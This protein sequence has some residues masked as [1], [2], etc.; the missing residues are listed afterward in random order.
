MAPIRRSATSPRASRPLVSVIINTLNRRESLARTLR[1]LEQQTHSG[2]EVVVVDGPSTDGTSEMLHADFRDRIRMM[3]C[4]KAHLGL[5]RNLG[6]AAA[7][8]EIVVFTDDDTVPPPGWLDVLV[9]AFQDPDV[10]AVG[11]P[12]FDEPLDRVLWK[13]CT[14][15][16]LG[17]PDTDSTLR[18]SDTLVPGADPFA[19][20]AG[21]NMGFRRAALAAVGGFHLL[22]G[23]SYDDVEVCRRLVDS[24][25][26][27][28]YEPDALLRHARAPSADRDGRH[29]PRDGYPVIHDRAVFALSC[30]SAHPTARIIDALTAFTEEWIA[31]AHHRLA[32]GDFTVAARDRFVERARAGL[33]DGIVDGQLPPLQFTVPD[34]PVSAFK[35]FR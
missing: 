22:L 31:S 23:S 11:G 2:F 34:A 12:V 8:G 21:C 5:S 27:I 18:P 25:G 16:R 17:E 26:H 20:L 30:P 13:R 19:Y 4:D 15:T 35:P 6:V 28:A 3:D 24:G 10:A 33:A 9:D 14:C 7:A 32:V 29:R 1:A